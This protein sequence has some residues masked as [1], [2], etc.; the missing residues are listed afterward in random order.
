MELNTIAKIYKYKRFDE[1][2]H[3]I[4]MAMQVHGALGCDMD[5]FI[6]ESGRLFHDR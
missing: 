4:L 1:G 3:F 2:H 6:R 5:Y